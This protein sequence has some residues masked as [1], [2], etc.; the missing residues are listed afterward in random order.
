MARK[1]HIPFVPLLLGDSESSIIF[2][3]EG[4]ANGIG[5]PCQ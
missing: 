2:D 1:L 3:L 5:K 4:S